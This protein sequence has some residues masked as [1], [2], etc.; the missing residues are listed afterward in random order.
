VCA[1]GRPPG[2]KPSAAPNAG[3]TALREE[4]INGL[5]GEASAVTSEFHERLSPVEGTL[6]AKYVHDL[7]PGRWKWSTTVYFNESASLRR[8]CS[9]CLGHW[10]DAFPGHLKAFAA[11]LCEMG[12]DIES[13]KRELEAICLVVRTRRHLRSD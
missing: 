10:C 2:R 4:F 12:H 9:E 3:I 1:K 6:G 8:G 7:R 13:V 11:E 5:R